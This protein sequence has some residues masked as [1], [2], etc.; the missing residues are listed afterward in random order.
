VLELLVGAAVFAAGQVTGRYLWPRHRKPP[1][2][3]RGPIC[4]CGHHRSLHDDKGKCHGGF[5]EIGHKP[6]A[7]VK[8]SHLACKCKQYVGPE[9]LPEYYAPELSA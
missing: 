3:V 9:P 6:I 8:Y 2:I 1:E 5:S 7:S 4:G